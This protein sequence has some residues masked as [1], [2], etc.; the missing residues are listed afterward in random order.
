VYVNF[1]SLHA[2]LIPGRGTVNSVEQ[3]LFLQTSKHISRDKIYIKTPCAFYFCS[4]TLPKY[5]HIHF[6]QQKL[7]LTKDLFTVFFKH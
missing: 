1:V 4:T 5:L 2:Y 6:L 3:S 7:K